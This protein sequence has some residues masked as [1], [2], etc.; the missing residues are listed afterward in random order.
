M[1]LAI[2]DLVI[3]RGLK[4]CGVWKSCNIAGSILREKCMRTLREYKV[5]GVLGFGYYHSIYS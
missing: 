3:F 1:R 5:N 2:S 4:R